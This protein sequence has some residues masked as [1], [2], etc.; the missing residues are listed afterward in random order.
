MEALPT[1]GRRSVTTTGI[2]TQGSS[3]HGQEL[4]CGSLVNSSSVQRTYSSSA[5]KTRQH[6]IHRVESLRNL[7]I[8]QHQRLFIGTI[9]SVPFY[10]KLVPGH[11]VSS[12]LLYLSLFLAESRTGAHTPLCRQTRIHNHTQTRL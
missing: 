5:L 6:H 9:N 8:G 12:F 4:Q 1:R 10:N 2:P 3:L 7:K 11:P